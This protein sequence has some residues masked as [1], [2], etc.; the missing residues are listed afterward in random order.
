[1]T[2]HVNWPRKHGKTELLDYVRAYYEEHGETPNLWQLL[3][4]REAQASVRLDR[5]VEG[6]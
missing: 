2:E 1:M 5:E 3:M 6:D 4:F